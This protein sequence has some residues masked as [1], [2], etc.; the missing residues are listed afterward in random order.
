MYIK[1]P[2]VNGQHWLIH[3]KA[4]KT[5]KIK[6]MIFIESIFYLIPNGSVDGKVKGKQSSC[7]KTV[8]INIFIIHKEIVV[9]HRRSRHGITPLPSFFNFL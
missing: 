3:A 4:V 7:S 6:T 9:K 2:I 8:C 5:I 1:L